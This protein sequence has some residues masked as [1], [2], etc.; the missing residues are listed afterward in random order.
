MR[1]F[2]G[3]VVAGAASVALGGC[4]RC[5]P[6]HTRQPSGAPSNEV[7][8]E[9]PAGGP[10]E[11]AWRVRWAQGPGK[12][13]YI[14]GAWFKRAPSKPWMQVLYDARVVELFVPY[15]SGS[16]RFYDLT[17]FNFGLVRATLAD[18][19]CCGALLGNPPVVVKEV[20]DRGIAWK[21]DTLVRRGQEL[22]L[23]GTLDAA[24]YNYVMEYGFRDDGVI[25]FRIGAT[26]RNLPGAEVESHMHNALWRID[27]DLN[28][29]GSDA[30]FLM[31][32]IEPFGSAQQ[33][34]D[35]MA[36]FN[37]GVE[38]N[39]TW[40]A[41]EF[42]M[43]EVEDIRTR[44]AK[45]HPIGYELMPFRRG[46]SRHA[47]AF[48]KQDFWVTR[49]HPTELT[50]TSLSSYANGEQVLDN[51][52]VLWH[53]TPVHH[54]PRDEDGEKVGGVWKGVAL[55]MWGGFDLKPRNLFDETPLHP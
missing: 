25:E 53:V 9:F 12:G 23:W 5:C 10:V 35:S 13:L 41:P 55:I 19:G 50:Y 24:N 43:V 52:I 20:R 26:A 39:A 45:S 51:D 21:D 28:G 6:T 14:T 17:S 11:T 46:S 1:W 15:H 37:G 44:N 18:K 48:T 3:I 33:A 40:V 30:A 36:P 54:Q 2:L 42:T 8:Q 16:P 29:A 47:E 34:K 22:V 32:H 7:V 31:R 38:G 49:W 4:R 27:M